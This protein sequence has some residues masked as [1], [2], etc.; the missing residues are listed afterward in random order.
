MLLHGGLSTGSD[1]ARHSELLAS[2]WHVIAPDSRGHGLSTN[3]GGDLRYSVM[4]DDMAAL[5]GV[6]GIQ[7]VAA[8]GHSDGGL[9]ALQI[10]FRHPELLSAIILDGV[11]HRFDS[12]YFAALDGF[13]QGAGL[14]SDEEVDNMEFAAPDRVRRIRETLA[15]QS[16]HQWRDLIK[17]TR[18][19]WTA[20][21]EFQIADLASLGIPTLVLVG[22]RD[23]FVPLDEAIELMRLVSES[24]LAVLPGSGHGDYDPVCAVTLVTDFLRRRRNPF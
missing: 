23:P 19:L 16:D 18:Q 20:P 14:G 12:R 3:P 22:D 21:R 24:E 10:A 15:P 6:L 13:F 4:A 7:H 8:W 5:C 2:N 9:V 1:W 17:Q 11:P